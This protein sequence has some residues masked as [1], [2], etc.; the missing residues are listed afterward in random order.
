VAGGEGQQPDLPGL[1]SPCALVVVDLQL[2]FEDPSFGAR[3]NPNCEQ[4]VA[5]LIAAWRER[6]QP[7]VFVRHESRTA[8]SPLAPGNPGNRFKP[9]LQG[10]PDLLVT[11]HVHSAFY[12]QPDL[13]HWLQDHGVAAVAICGITTDHCCETT[14]RMASDLGYATSFVLDAT[15]TFDRITPAGEVVSADEVSRATA[16]SLNREFA[17]VLAT[18]E[19]LDGL[20]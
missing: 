15:H 6:H 20:G 8:D 5:R 17:T 10:E 3:N 7:L 18:D 9:E 11:K 12:G 16:A 1:P 13:D 2:G 14:A 4:N 19:I